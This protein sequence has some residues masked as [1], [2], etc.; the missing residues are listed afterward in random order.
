MFYLINIY[1]LKNAVNANFCILLN[2]MQK[3]FKGFYMLVKEYFV[4]CFAVK[5]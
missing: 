4:L 3:H 5:Q 2:L 1:S